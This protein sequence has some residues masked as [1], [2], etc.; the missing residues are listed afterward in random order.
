MARMLF[1]RA[2]ALLTGL[3]IALCVLNI[4]ASHFFTT[5]AIS[6]FFATAAFA[7]ALKASKHG[8]FRWFA[9]AG[10]AVGLA[11]ASKPNMLITVGFLALPI[12]ETI[13]I[14]GLDMALPPVFRQPARRHL[15]RDRPPVIVATILAGIVAV[16]TFRI[17]QPYA[18]LGPD[19]WN[20]RLDP[21]W[22]STLQFWRDAQSGEID[23]PP[24][25]QWANRTPYGYLFE[26]MIRWGMGP[27]LGL[28]A[29]AGVI[30]TGYAMLRLRRWPNWFVLAAVA[31]PIVHFALY[32]G[33]VQVQRYLLTAYPFLIMFAAWFLVQLL[34]WAHRAP[35]RWYRWAHPGY[36]LPVIVIGYTLFYALA[37]ANSVYLHPHTRIEASNWIYENIPDGSVMT[38]E[39]W[40][41]GL[42]IRMPAGQDISFTSLQLEM[43]NRDDRTKIGNI[44]AVLDQADYV[45]T[46]SNRIYG[47]TAQMPARY[48]M[49]IAYYNALFDGSLGFELI[50]T[51]AHPPELFGITLDDEWAEESLT[52]YDHP[53]VMIFRKTDA[54]S[55]NAAW[56]TL[57]NALSANEPIQ[58]KAIDLDPDAMLLSERE[59]SDYAIA[60]T[61]SALFDRTGVIADWPALVWYLLLQAFA[62][63]AVMILW[64][65]FPSLPD[66]GYAL[67]KLVGLLLVSWLAWFLASLHLLE[68]TGTTIAIC[69][70]I[71][72]LAGVAS[73]AREPLRFLDDLMRRWRWIVVAEMVFAT[74]YL[75]ALFLRWQNADLWHPAR[76]GE[77]PMEFAYFNAVIKSPWFPPYD[78][79]FAGGVMHY[80]YWGYVPWAVLTKLSRIVPDVAFNLAIPAIFG[81]LLLMAWSAAATIIAR[82][83][84]PAFNPLRSW[85]API[86][87]LTAPLLVGFIGNLDLARRIGRGEYDYPAMPGWLDRVGPIG[88]IAHGIWN[89]LTASRSLPTDV[90]WGPTRVIPNTVNE[91]PYFSILFADFHAHVGAMPIVAGCVV[92]AAGI[93]GLRGGEVDAPQPGIF[94][95]LGG[96][97]LAVPAAML[98]GF[99]ATLLVAANTWDFA[100][101]LA[102]ILVCGLIA[103]GTSTGWIRPWLIVKDSAAFA[104]LAIVTGQIM[105][106]P[107][108]SRYGSLPT[109]TEPATEFSTLDAFLTVNGGLLFV[110]MGL[111]IA[112]MMALYRSLGRFGESGAATML[113][114]TAIAAVGCAIAFAIDSPAF[115]LVVLIGIAGLAVLTRYLEADHLFPLMLV[116]IALGLLIFPERFRL[117]NDVG[118]MNTVFK[119]Y[120]HAWVLLGIAGAITLPVVLRGAIDRY[121]PPAARFGPGWLGSRIWLAGATGVI[122]AGLMYPALAT[123]PRLDDRFND[124]DPTLDGMAY[125]RDAEHVETG[126]D[127]EP[128]VFPL[129]PDYQAIRWVQDTIAGTP[130]ILEGQMA[131]YRWGSRFSVYTGL[132]TVIGWGW[133]QT[134]QRPGYGDW[135]NERVEDVAWMYTTEE[136]F[137]AIVPTLEQYNVRLIV[138]GDL[139]RGIYPPEG[140]AKFEQ[141][142]TDGH[143]TRLYTN[144]R[145]IIYGFPVDS[146]DS[147]S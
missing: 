126:W 42:P 83:R 9:L 1:G 98:G 38:S 10:L 19:I 22:T 136:P 124:L 97:R 134:Q 108:T 13:R 77:K 96:W 88:E 61:W 26:T 135:I 113:V 101:S 54:W 76:G 32:G 92:I 15:D 118:R 90:F 131:Q 49:T 73:V 144:G 75:F 128:F 100:P 33:F 114:V 44:V 7:L 115:L 5:D 120:L 59:R 14:G 35:R 69:W 29:V 78:P 28:A 31:W 8:G 18:F 137:A 48:P 2:T 39:H 25:I 129:E 103:S 147:T 146:G 52:V 41:D 111:L 85:G 84:A 43:Y 4:Q 79:W 145:T 55:A 121:P 17:G 130:V 62:M 80:Y 82:L 74:G 116:G 47:S 119:F 53:T 87:A 109:G 140:L 56:L 16:I 142:V 12:L 60:G 65:V 27:P 94:T 3:L 57:D 133:H 112:G 68:F 106:F 23:M 36:V 70:G 21:R 67:A 110:I 50:K 102:L 104:A 63:P 71:V 117:A 51:V 34:R 99:A 58:L 125:M 123:G 138:V 86:L 40:D 72:V 143:L 46:S 37:F 139:E 45:I 64:R 11:G 89:A 66:R 24:S 20:I 30:W 127:G 6:A 93:V 141:A 91:F 105:L 132:P 81:L 95:T 122:L 107:Y